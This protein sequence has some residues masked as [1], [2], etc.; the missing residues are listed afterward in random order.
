MRQALRVGVRSY[1][2]KELEALAGFV[3]AADVRSGADAVVGF[4]EW[5]HTGAEERLDEIA[6][7]NE[8]DCRAT[9]ALRD[10]LLAQRPAGCCRG[11]S[12]PRAASSKRRAGEARGRA[13]RCGW[14]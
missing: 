11:R 10:W 2:L 3:R 9:L 4:E 1:S 6:A 13:R 7:Y 5:L 8:E 12:P 14:S